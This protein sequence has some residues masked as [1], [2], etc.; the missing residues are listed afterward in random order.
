MEIR[1]RE[2]E[3]IVDPAAMVEQVVTGFGFTEGPVWHPG[4]RSLIFSDIPGS[5]LYRW[6][7]ENG[8]ETI[9]EES[10]MANGN[11]YDRVGRLV[12]CEHGTSRVSR[13]DLSTSSYEVLATH[14]EG[15]ELN[16]PN[17]VVV[18]SDGR[19]YFTDPDYGRK[20]GHG[21]TRERELPFCGVYRLDLESGELALL[22][23]DFKKPNGLCF[24]VGE[25]LL[26]INDTANAHIRVF[27]V[28]P[29]GGV[30][31]GRLFANL[32]GEKVGFADGMKVDVEGN[33]YTCGPGGIQVFNS[34]GVCLGVIETPEVTANLTFGDDDRCSLYITANTSL[35]RV[36]VKIP[37]HLTFEG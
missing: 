37:G 6:T 4:E 5:K 15:K 17:D 32:T 19:I 16:S 35:Y 11:T 18:K 34:Q 30:A 26:Y 28:T 23:D 24:S 27:D 1:Q 13:T 3:N 31:N 25:S 36:R 7:A 21:I 14:F 8:L 10:N 9:R 20:P 33:V 29:D 22:V 2:F 12:T